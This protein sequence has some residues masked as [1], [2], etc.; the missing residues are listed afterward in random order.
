MDLSKGC[1]TFHAS[2][3][4]N[5][6]HPISAPTPLFENLPSHNACRNL[7]SSSPDGAMIDYRPS[8]LPPVCE[9]A[10]LLSCAHHLAQPPSL[11]TTF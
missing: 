10:Y 7:Y 1:R 2:L 9:L 3:Y 5:S 4:I 6:L 8:P 11:A